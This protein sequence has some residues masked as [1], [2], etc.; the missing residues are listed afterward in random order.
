MSLR[1]PN[2]SNPLVE[3]TRKVSELVPGAFDAIP[4]RMEARAP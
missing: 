3:R 2:I 4:W 1:D